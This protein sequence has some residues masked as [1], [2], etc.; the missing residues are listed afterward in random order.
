MVFLVIYLGSGIYFE[1]ISPQE[2]QMGFYI[3]SVVVAFMIALIVALLQTRH[4][5][6]DEKIHLCATGIGD[7]NITIM[8]FIFLIA[9]MFSGIATSAGGA[10]ST[11]NLLLTI[12]PDRFAIPG[13]IHLG[14]NKCFCRSWHRHNPFCDSGHRYRNFNFCIGVFFYGNRHIGD[15]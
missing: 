9:G 15:V 12:I 7:D 8:I 5:T 2:G 1:Y 11:A 13:L 10:S 3:M 6:F 14:Y 4:L